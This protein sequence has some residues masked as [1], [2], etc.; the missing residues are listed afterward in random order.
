MERAAAGAVEW[1]VLVDLAVRGVL[2]SRKGEGEEVDPGT[3]P[4]KSR[5]AP[6]NAACGAKAAATR[7]MCG[8]GCCIESPLPARTQ[9]SCRKDCCAESSADGSQGRDRGSSGDGW[10]RDPS[11]SAPEVRHPIFARCFDRLSPVI[12]KELARH[13]EEL[14][15]GL[16]GNVVEIG[17]GNGMNFRHYPA[18]VAHV[19]ALEPEAYLRQRAE[20]AAATSPVTVSVRDATAD[21]LPFDDESFDAAVACLVL[22]T[23]PD[24]ASALSELGRVLKPGAQL[25]FLEHVR[26]NRRR[27]AR[28]QHV[29]DRSGVWPWFAG[30]CHCARD[31]VASVEAAGFGIER[32]RDF[33]LGPSWVVTNPHVIGVARAARLAPPKAGVRPAADPAGVRSGGAAILARARRGCGRGLAGRAGGADAA[34]EPPKPSSDDPV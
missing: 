33:D 31:T 19:V 32:V 22:C 17:A 21:P 10:R 26:S 8:E 24:P 29:L 27:K 13:R 23:V 15:A 4:A 6:P 16:S 20:L 7:G 11:V 34:D 9:A 28:S 2:R 18:S 5:P 25:R 1:A 3:P 30:G 12:E 14:L